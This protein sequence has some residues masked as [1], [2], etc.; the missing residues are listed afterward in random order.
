MAFY[1]CTSLTSINLPNTITSIGA[2]A[3]EDCRLLTSISLPESVTSIGNYA[4]D[5]CT[6]LSSINIPNSVSSIGSSAFNGCSNLTSVTIPSSVTSIDNSTF[7]GCTGLTTI[8]IPN[9]VTSIGSSAFYNCTGLTSITIPNSVTSIGSSAFFGCTGLTSITIPNSVTS[10][11][12]S[13]FYQCSG[14]TSVT[15]PESVTSIGYHAFEGTPWYN[16][17]PDGVVYVGKVAYKYKGTMPENTSIVLKAGT[18]GIANYAFENCSGL[19]SVTI[20]ES[21]TSIGGNAFYNCSGLTSVTIPESVT[22]IGS[23]TF[24]GCSG[25]T[26]VTIPESVTSIGSSAFRGCS[27]LTSVIIPESVTLIDYG[28]FDGCTGLTSITIPNSVT[29]IDNFAFSG[30]SGLTSVTIPE[31][32]TSIGSYAFQNCSGLTSVT[33]PESVTSIGSSAFFGCSNLTSVTI[34]SNGIASNSYSS[35][36]TLKN[37]FGSQITEY[38]FGIGVVKIGNYACYDCRNLTF[39]TFSNSET[40]IGDYAFYGTAWYDNQPDGVVYVGKVAYKY[41]GT[42]PQNTNIV[43]NEGTLE[44]ANS[45]FSNCSGLTSITIPN[46]VTNIGSSAFQGCSNLTSAT[47]PESVTTIESSAFRHCSN[48]TSIN[49]P[50]SVTYIGSYAFQGCSNLTSINIPESVTHIGSYAFYGCSGLTYIAIPNSVTNIGS[51]AFSE[52]TGLAS[53]T[54]PENVTDVGEYAFSNTAWYNNLPD[55]MV[56]VGKIAYTYKGTIPLNKEIVLKDGIL[57]IGNYA[58]YGCST[59]NSITISNSVTNIGS[60]AFDGCSG[61]TSITIPNNVTIINDY[62]FYDCIGLTSIIIG[63]SVSSIGDRAFSY[64]PY[65]TRSYNSV[66][67]KNPIPP[68][69]VSKAFCRYD[70]NWGSSGLTLYVPHG[71]TSAYRDSYWVE[72]DHIIEFID[73]SHMELMDA[74]TCAGGIGTMINISMKNTDEIVGFQ[75][76]LVLP[77]DVSLATDTNGK[78]V[79]SLTNRADDHSLTINKVGDN[80]YRFICLSMNYKEFIGTDG[81]LVNVKIRANKSV[82]LGD[83]TIKIT[84][85]ELTNT[86]KEQIAATDATGT[87]TIHELGSGD[88]DSDRDLTYAD[89]TA[90]VNIILS[91]SFDLVADINGDSEITIADVTALTNLI[92]E[93][94]WKLSL[95]KTSLVMDIDDVVRLRASAEPAHYTMPSLTWSSS[96]ESVAEVTRAGLVSAVGYGTCTITCTAN[97]NSGNVATCEVMVPLYVT[98]ITLSKSNLTLPKNGSQVLTPTIA[99]TGATTKDVTWSS[100]NGNVATVDASGRVTAVGVGTCTITCAATDGSDV[101]ATC[102]VT[103]WDLVLSASSLSIELN[104]SQKLNVS[105]NPSSIPVPNVTWTTSNA[106][107]ATVNSSGRVSAVGYGSC[108]ISCSANDGSGIVA[109]CQVTVPVRVTGISLSANSLTLPKGNNQTLTATIA[110]VEAVS[111]GVV[112]TSSDLNV[113]TVDASGRVTAVGAGTC[114]ITCAATGGSSVTATCQVTVWELVLSATTLNLEVD[115]SRKLTVSTNPSSFPVPSVTWTS[116]DYNVADV[117]NKGVV[118]GMGPGTCTITCTATDGSGVS[119]SCTVNISE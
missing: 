109:T 97:D 19:T 88:V 11:G 92:M 3:F 112:W 43:L 80:T 69:F 32:V 34:N 104:Q 63:K 31:S 29:S 87:L 5:G 84:N 86:D 17:Q 105:T 50:E 103:V 73:N 106:S 114:T 70:V 116:S 37:F 76:D 56:Y 4:F 26:S 101:T 96:D 115:A 98:G 75:F 65:N 67:M 95:S 90:I 24:Y 47:I 27:G 79:A 22:N 94:T 2:G 35:S 119:A 110:P 1:E 39:I 33:I 66:R 30:C 89:I 74:S 52:C 16:N 82:E 41:K 10:I 54:I 117:T 13:A 20:P 6:T 36:S 111:F 72:F 108:V 28:T 61:L 55:G 49:I 93:K 62:A 91:D 42:M 51:Y 8:T 59:M 18:L 46:S 78:Y 85:T 14:L 48:L 100:S 102:E 12:S 53:I 99:P 64:N 107:V 44:I 58:F 7:S 38:V 81:V 40:L 15:I 25:L 68:S 23:S 9:S 71:R 118:Y 60:H 83:Y 113:A 45:A 57:K 21:V 77:E